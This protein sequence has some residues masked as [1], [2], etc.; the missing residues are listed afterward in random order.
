[1]LLYDGAWS[2]TDFECLLV[3]DSFIFLACATKVRL[4]KLQDSDHERDAEQPNT[5]RGDTDNQI[6]KSIG[7][8]SDELA[9]QGRSC[10]RWAEQK[11][12]TVFAKCC[13]CIILL[14]D[15]S[16]TP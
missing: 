5:T 4:L 7:D 3:K 16:R 10:M 13:S 15:N 2:Q 11:S 9:G 6:L 1:M 14:K 12:R 8:I